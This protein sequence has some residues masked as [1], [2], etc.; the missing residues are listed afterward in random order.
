M[1]VGNLEKVDSGSVNLARL[2]MYFKK[3]VKDGLGEQ[4][5]LEEVRKCIFVL[6][7]KIEGKY[8]DFIAN[9]RRNLAVANNLAVTNGARSLMD[10]YQQRAASPPK[11]SE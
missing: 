10:V 1:D 4:A 9:K 5:A 6:K 11:P 2:V 3:R 7:I 8:R